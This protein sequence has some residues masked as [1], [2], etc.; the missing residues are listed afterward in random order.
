MKGN[1]L[2]IKIDSRKVVLS[3][4]SLFYKTENFIKQTKYLSNVDYI[5]SKFC[6]TIILNIKE[7]TQNPIQNKNLIDCFLIETSDK[8]FSF[9]FKFGYQVD[10]S[11]NKYDI[12]FFEYIS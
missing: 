12:I 4:D 3:S 7:I 5:L 10:E 1:F 6:Q 2:Q 8:A 9:L 11:L